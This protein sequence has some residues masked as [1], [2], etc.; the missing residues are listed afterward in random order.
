MEPSGSFC[1]F[2]LLRWIKEEVLNTLIGVAELME[3]PHR[4]INGTRY[5]KKLKCYFG[6]LDEFS[7][8]FFLLSLFRSPTSYASFCSK[9]LRTSSSTRRRVNKSRLDR[10]D[11]QA[12]KV[13]PESRRKPAEGL[14]RLNCNCKPSMIWFSAQ[15]SQKSLSLSSLD[16]DG[17]NCTVKSSIMFFLPHH[18]DYTKAHSCFSFLPFGNEQMFAVKTAYFEKVVFNNTRRDSRLAIR[19][20]TAIYSAKPSSGWEI[21]AARMRSD[22]IRNAFKWLRK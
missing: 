17:L 13:L 22:A 3:L 4:H 9:C 11:F 5:R 7:I 1:F 10:P 21:L 19:S 15:L 8:G 6:S 16:S 2:Y 14:K 18:N 12:L 20:A